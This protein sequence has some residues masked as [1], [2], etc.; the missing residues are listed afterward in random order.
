LQA[1]AAQ[2]IKA[3]AAYNNYSSGGGAEIGVTLGTNNDP[4]LRVFTQG[5]GYA[6]DFNINNNTSSATALNVNNNGTGAA[7]KFSA[8]TS[9]S[10]L[11]VTNINS[12]PGSYA[13]K[14]TSPSCA[15]YGTTVSGKALEGV[16]TATGTGVYG[17]SENSIAGIFQ[18]GNSTAFSLKCDGNYWVTS[19]T[20]FDGYVGM[21]GN[22]DIGYRLFVYGSAYATGF[23]Q[24]SDANLKNNIRPIGSA[25][26]KVSMLQGVQY[27]WNEPAKYGEGSQIGF[28]AQDM[29]KVF[30][31]LVKSTQNGYAIQYAP[32]T[33]VLVEAVKEVNQ[34]NEQLSAEV[35]ILR[36][37]VLQLQSKIDNMAGSK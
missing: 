9:F 31:E 20:R 2:P 25:L 29:Q 3:F 34:K 6:G 11:E 23:W 17:Y 24:S 28:L 26:S 21:G 22:W 30:P 10:A 35:G 4:A 37:L 1:E 16:A 27:D 8:N 7:G 18:S 32:L 33:A 5:T 19:N 36:Q 14:A 13:V 12:N 15:V